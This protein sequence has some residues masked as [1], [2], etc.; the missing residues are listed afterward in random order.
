MKHKPNHQKKAGKRIKCPIPIG[1]RH[2]STFSTTNYRLGHD[3]TPETDRLIKD[4]IEIFLSY[5]RLRHQP[6]CVLSDFNKYYPGPAENSLKSPHWKLLID[7]EDGHSFYHTLL[8]NLRVRDFPNKLESFGLTLST[9]EYVN[10]VN[11]KTLIL[12]ATLDIYQGRN[13]HGFISETIIKYLHAKYGGGELLSKISTMKT[14]LQH[15]SQ[16]LYH[17]LADNRNGLISRARISCYSSEVEFIVASSLFGISLA[18]WN[19]WQLRW[20]LF[21]PI[22]AD[23]GPYFNYN[24]GIRPGKTPQDP[25]IP[26]NIDEKCLETGCP[27]IIFICY[28]RWGHCDTLFPKF[29]SPLNFTLNV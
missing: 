18:R 14:Q 24:T 6:H 4:Q 29:I 3:N 11:L 17:E 23:G 9:L 26:I 22:W 8:R 2:S 16:V 7:Q 13:Y 21:H 12:E 5:C 27:H 15:L 1:H 19:N 20:K 10:I 28:N 25:S